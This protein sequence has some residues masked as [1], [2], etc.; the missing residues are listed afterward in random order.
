MA[1]LEKIVERF[2]GESQ[3]LVESFIFGSDMREQGGRGKINARDAAVG[4][5]G[6]PAGAAAIG[7]DEV[8][9]VA[10]GFTNEFAFEGFEAL[11]ISRE[12]SVKR[13]RFVYQ[14]L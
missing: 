2:A 12:R 9:F 13:Y 6:G 1:R 4:S 11:P 10:F 3:D 5:G 7:D 8:F 14:F